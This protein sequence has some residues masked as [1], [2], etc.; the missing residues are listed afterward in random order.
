MALD[1][2]SKTLGKKQYHIHL[3]PG[4]IGKYVLLPGDPARSDRV[5]KYLDNAELV[6]N[7]REHRTFTGYYKGVRVSVTSTGMGCPSAAI[8]A[9]ELMNIGAECLIRIGSSAALQDGI[10]IGDLM[11]S[12]GSMKNEGTSRFYVPDCF[13]SVPDFDL[14]R[15]IIDTAREMQPELKGKVFYGINAS[16]DA[17]YGETQE[18]IEKLSSYGCLN[19]EMESSAL[20]TV[21][22]RRKKRA[23]MISAVSG[24]LI[25]GEVIYETSNEGLATGWD[26][27]I[28]V[29]LEA[30]Y[31]F[32]KE[33]GGEKEA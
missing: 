27:E 24:N 6:A 18:W 15:T 1:K 5:A 12:T 28:R 7:N 31:R 30:I 21:C 13:P 32:E 4:D 19:V 22:T 8:A 33:Q 20:Y 23:A 16:D 17:F 29:V 10:S 11:I 26:V 14:T 9:E 3:K 2:E 25:T